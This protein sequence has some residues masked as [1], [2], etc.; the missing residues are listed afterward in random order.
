MRAALILFAALLLPPGPAAAAEAQPIRGLSAD[1]GF[2]LDPIVVTAP[3]DRITDTRAIDPRI[4]ATLLRLL[5]QRSEV[6]PGEL[7]TQSTAI[8]VFSDLTTLTGH[9][10]RLRYTELGFLLTEGLAGVKDFQLQ[11]E[12]EKAGRDGK[13][14][15]IRAAAMVALGYAKDE[16]FLALFRNGMQ[17]SDITARVGALESMILLDSEGARFAI[18]DSARSDAS[19]TIRVMAAASLWKN[20]DVSGREVLLDYTRDTDWFVRAFAVYYIGEH[21]RG[22]E[23]RK[24]MDLLTRESNPIVKAEL[25]RALIRLEKHK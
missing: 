10:L 4:N 9:K 17:D 13:N 6:R 23:Y 8:G 7:G 16:N 2:M 18:A 3:R 25:V 24:L 15:Q 12:L 5:R 11:Q 20:G 22:D 21:G 14:P 19:A 1:L